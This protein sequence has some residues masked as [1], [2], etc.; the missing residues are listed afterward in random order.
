[1]CGCD[2][3]FAQVGVEGY[4]SMSVTLTWPTTPAISVSLGDLAATVL[5]GLTGA[6]AA[7]LNAVASVPGASA[8]GAQLAGKFPHFFGDEVGIAAAFKQQIALQHAVVQSP[9]QI[10]FGAKAALRA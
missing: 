2:A 10:G 8:F 5:S 4:V 1:V 7:P 3:G 6:F 9:E